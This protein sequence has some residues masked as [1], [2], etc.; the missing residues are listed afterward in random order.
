MRDLL[1]HA[2]CLHMD[3]AL[4]D[5]PLHHMALMPCVLQE[6]GRTKFKDIR[7]IILFYF[8]NNKRINYPKPTEDNI[9]VCD[10]DQFDTEYWFNGE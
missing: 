10:L 2:M 7:K 6:I 5:I 8:R 1:S 3:H 9:D 4:C